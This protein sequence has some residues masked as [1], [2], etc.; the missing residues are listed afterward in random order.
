F[1]IGEFG[2][3]PSCDFRTWARGADTC[4]INTIYLVGYSPSQLQSRLAVLKSI[5]QKA[6]LG[7][8]YTGANTLYNLERFSGGVYARY[9]G[10]HRYYGKESRPG[11][12]GSYDADSNAWFCPAPP[13]HGAGYALLWDSL[14]CANDD[15]NRDDLKYRNRT[16]REPRADDATYL[17]ATRNYT[18]GFRVKY[19]GTAD[20]SQVCKIGMVP[21]AE[22]LVRQSDSIMV[23]LTTDSFPGLDSYKTFD[24][25]FSRSF[26]D[27]QWRDFVVYT[28]GN[29]DL[30]VD[31]VEI[32]DAVYDSLNSNMYNQVIADI[33]KTYS[34][35]TAP[36]KEAV[37]RYMLCDEPFR[38]QFKADSIVQSQLKLTNPSYPG[39][40]QVT[41]L[42]PNIHGADTT[43][44]SEFINAVHPNELSLNILPISG[45]FYGNA[46]WVRTPVDSGRGLQNRFDTMAIALSAA[47]HACN[48]ADIPLYVQIQSFGDYKYQDTLIDTTINGEGNFRRPTP[49]EISCMANLSL[50]YGA[51]G[52]FYY[53]YVD[54]I[55][56]YDGINWFYQLGLVK[57]S[58]KH[59]EPHWTAVKNLNGGIKALSPTLM[60]LAWETAFRKNVPVGTYL[61]G[62]SDSLIQVGMFHHK[63]NAD[64]K[65]FMLVNRHCLPAD[66]MSA[67]V[68][69]NWTPAPGQ[70][71][72]YF[73]T[74]VLDNQ[75][76]TGLLTGGANQTITIKLLPGGGRLFRII[77]FASTPKL[78]GGAAYINFRFTTLS[79]NITSTLSND[80][81]QITQKYWTI[82]QP[83]TTAK[84][85]FGYWKSITSGWL[86]YKASSIQYLQKS[87]ENKQNIFELQYKIDGGKITTP[88]FTG[89]IYFND[90]PPGTGAVSINNNATFTNSQT[91]NVKLTGTDAFPGLSQMRF[92]ETPFGNSSGYANLVKNG[93]FDNTTSW[94]LDNAEFYNGFLHLKGYHT[95]PGPAQIRASAKQIIP[96]TELTPFKNKL[97]RLTDDVYA[98]DVIFSYK[99]VDVF[100]ADVVEPNYAA[101]VEPRFVRL[102]EKPIASTPEVIWK[103]NS[104][105]FTL[106]VDATRPL[107]RMEVSYNIYGITVPPPPD[108]DALLNT[109]AVDNIRLEPV[110]VLNST[111]GPYVYDGWINC[112]TIGTY[113]CALSLG[114]GT[115]RVYLQLKDLAGNISLEPGW[116]DNIVLD[117][118]LPAATIHSPR[119]RTNV[120]V[121]TF[122]V[123]C[124]VNDNFVIKSWAL[125]LKQHNLTTWQTVKSGIYR[126]TKRPVF[127]NCDSLGMV[128]GNCYDFQLM[129]TDSACN[130]GTATITIYYCYN[131][132]PLVGID[133]DFAVFSSL[134]VDAACDNWGNIYATDTQA[135][136]I[137]EFSP[138]GD[139][140]LCFG[141]KSTGQNPNG[142]NQPQGIAVDNSGVIYAADCYNHRVGRFNQNGELIGWFG[143]KGSNDGEFNQP[144]GLA[145]SNENSQTMLYVT[146]NKNNRVQKFKSDGT[147]I[148]A[149]GKDVLQQPTGLAARNDAVENETV[150]SI[151]VSDSKNN[152]VAVFDTSGK[153]VDLLGAGLDLKQP[154]DVCFDIYNNLY[155]ADVYNNR[156]IELDPWH[157]ALLTFGVQGQEAG[158]FKLPQGLAVSPD[159]KYVYVVD[160]HNNRIQRFKMY[161]DMDALGGPQLAGKRQTTNSVPTVFGLSQC[162]PNPCQ[163]ATTINYQLAKQGRVSLKVYNTLGQAVKTLVNENQQPGY[164]SIN[165]DGKDE[166]NRQAATGIYFYRLQTGSFSDT[167]KAMVLR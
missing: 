69:L 63:T 73:I 85:A 11:R 83:E 90:V 84:F 62:I 155:I 30:Y 52:L 99:I 130:N 6:L 25:K 124:T 50:C 123:W 161:F 9:E 89:Q 137:W 110:S 55:Y 23:T 140:L 125:E 107:G 146:D 164:Y 95:G 31:Y 119:N 77:P 74:D 165:W 58:G 134:P 149:F 86:P 100:Y 42:E 7:I 47:K 43:I 19:T 76:I 45:G 150:T 64:D 105:T 59:N 4:N 126:I 106:K 147:F 48:S 17:G 97:L 51:T 120:N 81:I 3:W 79:P 94:I 8:C 26:Y 20:G 128:A 104:D 65:Y 152:R 148:K 141:S 70:P 162:Y 40:N 158:Q 61:T 5:G 151:Y 103:Q 41:P 133:P 143:S 87:E 75:R 113:Q 18:A 93:T 34:G 54:N 111:A 67:A 57:P 68:T 132:K 56:T 138:A 98:H 46:L 118:T 53:V 38:S 80:S 39:I 32:Q 136:K 2:A 153:I 156:V 24:I 144:I 154:W 28:Y 115:K 139:V 29:K 44:Y 160:T 127:I 135:D 129:A 163:Q 166:S 131:M 33:A 92:A 21:I 121:D 72:T 27:P 22:D 108:D 12:V 37:F 66:T 71:N 82:V 145:I 15:P 78:E 14:L 16:C 159:G 1:P 36:N 102:L 10:N 101:T 13:I 60:Q 167:K 88:K 35:P 122:S 96:G 142:F 91:V 157:N 117:Q 49:R 109:I 116:S 112:D 114:D